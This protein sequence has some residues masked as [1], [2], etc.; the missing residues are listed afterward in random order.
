MLLKSRSSRYLKLFKKKTNKQTNKQKKSKKQKQK[1][2][3]LLLFTP[4]VHKDVEYRYPISQCPL[5]YNALPN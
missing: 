1:T 5:T 3:N 2:N 4:A